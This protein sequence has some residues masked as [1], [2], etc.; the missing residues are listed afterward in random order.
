LTFPLRQSITTTTLLL[1]SCNETV[2]VDRL[3]Y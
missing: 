2:V 1:L 3:S